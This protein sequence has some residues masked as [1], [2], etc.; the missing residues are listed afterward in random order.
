MHSVIPS[1]GIQKI[2]QY[3]WSLYI[4]GI[5]SSILCSH[6]DMETF[7]CSSNPLE[8]LTGWENV[9]N[10]WRVSRY[11][12][13]V[14]MFSRGRTIW[15]LMS[16]KTVC[17]VSEVSS[18]YITIVLA[19]STIPT[20]AL[21]IWSTWIS[22]YLYFVTDVHSWW[23]DSIGVKISCL[24]ARWYYL[25]RQSLIELMGRHQIHLIVLLH[26]VHAME[27]IRVAQSLL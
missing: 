14:L 24:R 20:N 21:N 2:F 25:G 11:Q 19:H 15:L 27:F 8:W 4:F 9:F 3:T 16:M 22:I 7:Q 1:Y 13:E 6:S 17:A 23:S 26:T 10:I 5:E 12:H 18:S